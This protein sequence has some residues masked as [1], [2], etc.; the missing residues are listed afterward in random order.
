MIHDFDR[1][2]WIGASDVRYVMGNW[3]GKSFENWYYEKLGFRQNRFQNR[4]MA[5]GNAWEHSVLD[6]LGVPE[7]VK[8]SQFK[9]EPIL[10]RVNLDGNTQ[11]KIY[12]VKTY[13]LRKG[14]GN[15]VWHKWQVQVQMYASG[16]HRG[17]IVTYGLEESDYYRLGAV[18]LGRLARIEVPYDPVWLNQEYLPRHMRL[19][20]AMRKREFPGF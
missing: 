2:G 19:I 15:P 18:D 4:F 12:E 16:I 13:R 5:S 8:D 9:M 10:L 1:S 3:R 6:A 7:M 17:E 14:Y 11:D 20:E